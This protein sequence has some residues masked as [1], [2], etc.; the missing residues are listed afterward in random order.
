MEE[1]A[2]EVVI[3]FAMLQKSAPY[4]HS[5]LHNTFTMKYITALLFSFFILSA[6]AQQAVPRFAVYFGNPLSLFS[7]ARI[8]FEYRITAQ[9]AIQLSTASY[10]GFCRGSQTG[11]EYRNYRLPAGS[12]RSENFLYAKVGFGKS[13]VTNYQDRNYSFGLGYYNYAGGGIG[14]HFTLGRE[15]HFFLDLAAGAKLV[16]TN[17]S[18]AAIDNGFIFYTTGPGSILDLNMHFGWQF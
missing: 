2:V 9:H 5:H 3:F 18:V 1:A 15:R 10:H 4:L 16:I 13:D 12:R 14:R 17:R 7:K 6:N 8:K 11:F